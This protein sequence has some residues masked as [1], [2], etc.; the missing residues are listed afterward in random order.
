[1][2]T[3][4][5]TA[6]K[7]QNLSNSF[8]KEQ[9][10]KGFV[11]GV[12]YH[13][14]SEPITIFVKETS[15]NRFIYSSE[16]NLINLDIEGFEKPVTCILKD[17]QFDPVNDRAIHFDLQGIS[18]KEK[19]KVEVPLQIIGSA[20]GVRDGGI[21]QQVLHT[22]EI[23]CL[24]KDIPPHIEVDISHLKIGDAI[25]LN[26]IKQEGFEIMDSLESAIVAVVPPAVEKEV[27]PSGE[28]EATAEEPEVI[29]KGKKEEEEEE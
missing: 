25:H 28:E 22:V 16:V 11:P 5:L 8:T 9:R 3:V 26:D 18:E 7:R 24:P 21:L 10:K 15:L 20:P 27:T 19:I 29:S 1:M 23:E 6:Q 4:S 14:N 12:F 13:K 17:V 2:A